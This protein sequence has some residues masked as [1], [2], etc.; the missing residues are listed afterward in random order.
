MKK[1]IDIIIQTFVL[2]FLVLTIILPKKA[3]S[4]NENRYLQK[5]P[6]L[7]VENLSSG[8]FMTQMSSYIADHF[9]L[10]ESFLSFKTNIFKMIGIKRQNDVY[11]ADDDYLI[12]EYDKPENN[13]KIINVVN[14]FIDMIPDVKYEFMLVPT[15]AY[16][17]Q[18]KIPHYNLNYDEKS[19][20]DFFKQ[21]FKGNYV[22]V[23][24]ILLSNSNKYI[25]YRTDHHWTTRGAYYAY[26]EYCK[27][28]GIVPHDYT[29]VKVSEDFY[30]T[31]YSK[32]L[33]GTIKPDIIEKIIDDNQYI[34][35]YA[36]LNTNSMYGE[37]FLNEKDKYSFFLNGNQSLM[38]I[39]NSNILDK[40]LLIIKDSYAN[41][42]I[43]LIAS[44]YSK[45]H[46]ID[47]RYYKNKISDYLKDNNIKHVL[48]LYN[49]G[50]IDDDLGILSIN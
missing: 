8:Q 20:I 7:N 32:V 38:T 17:Y 1:I 42:F 14:R 19:T 28:N 49:I 24:N 31:I 46:V 13:K 33:D 44:H 34:V 45:I 50:T 4:E 22:D 25:Y 3:F 39:S 6:I 40:E 29:F 37:K 5:F 9:P 35:K 41:S 21:N 23:S 16:I 12:E 36:N 30:G 43:P 48:F 2:L 27:Q 26:Y 18:D 11:Y 15:A 47:P 10:R